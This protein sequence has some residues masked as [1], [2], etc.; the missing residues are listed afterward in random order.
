M[1]M[2]KSLLLGSAA[3]LVAVATAQAADLPVKAK[4]VQY[5]KICT[6]YGA[7][8]YYIPGSDICL[9]IGG[10]MRQEIM[11]G[12]QGSGSNGAFNN[13]LGQRQ[14]SNFLMRSRG[15]ITADA[16]S[17][18]AYGTVRGYIS[19]GTLYDNP[20][21]STFNSNRNFVQFAG[22]TMG[23]A[24]S[25]YD[26]YNVAASSYW[27]NFP[28]SDTGD[29]GWK[30]FAYTAQFGNGLSAT[31][32]AEEPRRTNIFNASSTAAS[33]IA[34]PATNVTT[35]DDYV[36]VRYP[37]IVANLRVDQAWGSA[38]LMGAVHDAS[39]AYN[40]TSAAGALNG[41]SGHP[42]DKVGYVIGGGV[43]LNAPMLGAGDWFQ[44][45]ANYTAGALGYIF[46]QMKSST[47]GATGFAAFNGAGLGLGYL[48][49]GVF[50]G[51]AAAATQTGI[52]LTKAWSIN[53]SYE[54][55]WNAAWQTSVYGYYAAVNYSATANA[56]LCAMTA[57]LSAIPAANCSNNWSTWGIGSRTQWN[58][59]KTFYMG[60]DVMYNKLK[61]ADSGA[62]VTTSAAN[63]AIPAG[64]PVTLADRDLWQFR[65][66]AHRDFGF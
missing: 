28:F 64:F 5:V 17:Q 55:F 61:T 32:S 43:R 25:F 30:V 9:K 27:G 52:E 53:A 12:P 23:T 65:F 58:V 18:T 35:P 4:P 63:G 6:L 34:A 8:F 50:T 49:D 62:T 57:Y 59:T 36:G 40:Y 1:K 37:D 44:V 26:F 45:Q 22:F 29:G 14:E 42:S 24:V 46:S 15:Y 20:N 13:Y 11:Q 38:Q 48:T 47:G 51:T 31:L 19:L 16:R 7:G 56:N 2:V 41:N 33:A 39:A 54:H 66:R 3:G 60:V 21:G 10:Y